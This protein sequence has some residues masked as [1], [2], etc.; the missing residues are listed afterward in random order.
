MSGSPKPDVAVF[1]SEMTGGP[2]YL[3]GGVFGP[4][5]SLLSLVVCSL[6]GIYFLSEAAAQGKVY[7]PAWETKEWKLREFDTAVDEENAGEKAPLLAG[8]LPVC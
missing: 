3:T 8:S 5:A 7:P 2:W 1:H 4:E 6:V